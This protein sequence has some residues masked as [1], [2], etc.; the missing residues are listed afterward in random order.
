MALTV[1]DTDFAC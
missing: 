1:V